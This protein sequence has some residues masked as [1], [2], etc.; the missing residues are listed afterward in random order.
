[1]TLSAALAISGYR[2]LLVDLDSQA[3]ASLSLGVKYDELTPSSADVLFHG[4]HIEKAIRT[5]SLEKFHL[6]TGGIE[7]SHSDLILSD[8][9]GR[10]NKLAEALFCIK[11][12]YDFIICDC[13]PSLSMI[14][15]NAFV[16][17]D[18]Y[19]VPITPEYLALEGLV[20]LMDG[21]GQI[22][23]GMEIKLD[24]LGI[25]FTMVKSPLIRFW[26]SEY[27][28]QMEIINLVKGH[29]SERVFKTL[30]RKDLNRSK[31][32]SY[33]KP[34]FQYLQDSAGADDYR[35]LAEEVIIRCNFEK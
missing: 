29:Y 4:T 27:K 26:D 33:G 18:K 32:P 14:P 21:V 35:S 8:V 1:V 11:S 20:S 30:I 22:E 34:V 25:V 12:D 17:S 28:H 13:A 6:L 16:A 2:T 9:A 10:E 3:S 7:L 23:T 15:V 24:L 5:T 19:I 31:A